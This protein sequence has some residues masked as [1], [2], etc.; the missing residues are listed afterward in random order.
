[1]CA[2]E[3]PKLYCCKSSDS[4]PRICV[5]K[6]EKIHGLFLIY[7]RQLKHCFYNRQEE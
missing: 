6:L 1:M 2:E 3:E 7:A 4:Y 5:E